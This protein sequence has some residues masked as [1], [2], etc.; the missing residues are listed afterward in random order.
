MR[1]NTRSQTRR[2]HTVGEVGI[3]H[4]EIFPDDDPDGVVGTLAVAVSKVRN[5]ADELKAVPNKRGDPTRLSP[6]CPRFAPSCF[7]SKTFSCSFLAVRTS[8]PH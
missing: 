6:G 4:Q 1:C 2:A 5:V 8:R 7:V 3:P